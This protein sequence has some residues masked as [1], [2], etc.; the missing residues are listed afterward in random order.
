MATVSMAD[1]QRK[2]L[3]KRLMQMRVSLVYLESTGGM[4]R[5]I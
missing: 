3:D 1:L 5:T 4:R 2:G